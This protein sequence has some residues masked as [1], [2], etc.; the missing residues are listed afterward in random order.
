V[1]SSNRFRK[2]PDAIVD[3]G[4][5]WAAWLVSDTITASAWLV[6]TGITSVLQTNTTT[7]ATI[8]LSGGTVGTEYAL[9]NRI[10]TVGGRTQDQTIYVTIEE[11]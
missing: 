7:S 10:T 8:W 5:P 2:D 9:R 3:F 4:V 11:R 1:G 6:P